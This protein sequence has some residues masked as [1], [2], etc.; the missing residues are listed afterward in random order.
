MAK[1]FGKKPGASDNE[2]GKMLVEDIK[3]QPGGEDKVTA[4]Q[5]AFRG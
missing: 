5:A 1:D 2:E 4:I 3:K